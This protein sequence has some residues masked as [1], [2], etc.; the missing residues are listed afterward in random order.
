MLRTSKTG[1]EGLDFPRPRFS[2]VPDANK[3]WCP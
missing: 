2:K 3:E 1:V